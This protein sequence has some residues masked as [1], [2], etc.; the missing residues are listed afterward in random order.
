MHPF[1]TVMVPYRRIE[2]KIRAILKAT[3]SNIKQTYVLAVTDLQ[4]FAGLLIL[5][6][7]FSHQRLSHSLLNINVLW[8][9]SILTYL[10]VIK[11]CPI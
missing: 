6:T 4:Y 7:S 2:V 3:L 10:F 5:D 8:T 11:S 9:E 1:I